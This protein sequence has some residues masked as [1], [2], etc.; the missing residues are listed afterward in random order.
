MTVAANGGRTGPR[1]AGTSEPA[2]VAI[3]LDQ[4]RHTCWIGGP[5]QAAVCSRARVH[6]WNCLITGLCVA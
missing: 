5:P 6:G 2:R 1:R 3:G 4:S